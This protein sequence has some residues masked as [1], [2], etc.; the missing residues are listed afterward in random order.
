ML[1]RY[2]LAGKQTLMAKVLDF[3]ISHIRRSVS[4]MTR[5]KPELMRYR[6]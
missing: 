1:C 2:Q 6:R 5:D 4:M 3:G